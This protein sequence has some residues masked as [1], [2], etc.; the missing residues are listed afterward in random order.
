MSLDK[1]KRNLALKLGPE[2]KRWVRIIDATALAMVTFAIA[3]IWFMR[4]EQGVKPLFNLVLW[5]AF[6]SN[7]ILVFTLFRDSGLYRHERIAV[8]GSTGATGLALMM[9]LLHLTQPA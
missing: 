2:T 1:V 7:L 4:P 6:G 9:L 8:L 3:V 5:L